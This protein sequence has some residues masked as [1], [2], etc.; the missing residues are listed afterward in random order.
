MQAH[1]SAIGSRW[2]KIYE[3]IK[4][5][6]PV[7]SHNFGTVTTTARLGNFLAV[8]ELKDIREIT[9]EMASTQCTFG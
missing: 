2:D 7:L 4:P 5:I 3:P 1:K 6:G 8:D 9:G